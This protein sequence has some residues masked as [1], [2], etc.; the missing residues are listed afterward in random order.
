MPVTPLA[1]MSLA[2]L[3][4]ASRAVTLTQNLAAVERLDTV[5]AMVR[6]VTARTE[7]EETRRDDEDAA[8]G[9]PPRPGYARLAPT[10]LARSHV[11]TAMSLPTW[12]ADRMITA[13]V[14]LHTRLPV[15]SRHARDGVFDE[16]MIVDLACRLAEVPDHLVRAV[17]DEVVYGLRRQID[18]GDPPTRSSLGKR[19]DRAIERRDP[20]EVDRRNQAARDNRRVT[21]RPRGQ[22]LTSMS[23]LLPDHDAATLEARLRDTAAADPGDERTTAQRLADALTDLATPPAEHTD[24]DDSARQGRRP[25]LDITVIAAAAQGL[26]Q[27]VELIQSAYASFDWLCT[28]VL[29]EENGGAR[30][31]LV[32]PLPGAQDHYQDPLKYFVSDALK[33]R[34][35]LRDGTCRHPGCTVKAED[36]EI[37]H[38]LTFYKADPTKGGPT[39]ECNLICLC[40]MHHQE[41]TFGPWTYTP[42]PRG[43]GELI[44]RT[45]TGHTYRTHPTGPLALARQ[46]LTETALQRWFTTHFNNHHPPDEQSPQDQPPDS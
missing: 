23:A 40:K 8:A 15:L 14:Q 29:A 21:F 10:R 36:C 11:S 46:H 18:D 17:E 22:G 24:T 27:R 2:E 34:I 39:A 45:D 44:I 41:K 19:I 9:R 20:D 7:A 32:D 28:Q 16:A 26:P 37:D 3:V 5:Y 43:D 35:R 42:G 6:A 31:R 1:S 33:H 30:F 38:V 4:E 12:H 25:R 13:A